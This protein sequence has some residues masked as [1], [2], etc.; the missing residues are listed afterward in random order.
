MNEKLEYDEISREYENHH[1][2][3]DMLHAAV[4]SARLYAVTTKEERERLIRYE[5]L[6]VR[7]R[8]HA[9]EACS[10]ARALHVRQAFLNKLAPKI[11]QINEEIAATFEDLDGIKLMKAKE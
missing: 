10:A 4:R 3:L 7:A 11:E 1:N 2:R 8:Q 6:L 5:R 9:R